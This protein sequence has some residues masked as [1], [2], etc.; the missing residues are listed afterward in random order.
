MCYSQAAGRKKTHRMHIILFFQIVS[1]IK[2]L[3]RLSRDDRCNN[4]K[5]KVDEKKNGYGLDNLLQSFF[6]LLFQFI[7]FNHFHRRFFYTLK[8]FRKALSILFQLDSSVARFIFV[9]FVKFDIILSCDTL[10]ILVLRARINSFRWHND[11]IS[12]WR[13][14]F[15][16]F[17]IAIY[18]GIYFISFS[19]PF[20][21]EK[22]HF[23]ETDLGKTFI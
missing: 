20:H 16:R 12:M 15:I 9:F 2:M 21:L 11:I 14:D 13:I 6:L 8:A 5:K 4:T 23:I 1:Y 3:N 7:W 22:F 19:V 17:V 10:W 18:Y